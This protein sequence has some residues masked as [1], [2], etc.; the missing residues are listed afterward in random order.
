[1]RRIRVARW[2]SSKS[3]ASRFGSSSPRSIWSSS[4]IIRSTRR[5]TA[6]GQVEEHRRDA[7]P[8]GGLL[9]R[10]PDRLAVDHVE[11]LGHLADLV[12]V[13]EL[14]RV[15]DLADDVVGAAVAEVAHVAQPGDRLGQVAVGHRERAL[16]QPAQREVERAGQHDGE[17]DGD[18]QDQQHQDRPRW[19]PAGSPTEL[20][21]AAWSHDLRLEPLL[22]PAHQVDDRAEGLGDAPSGCT[23]V[24]ERLSRVETWSARLTASP[25]TVLSTSARCAGVA[26]RAKASERLLLAGLVAMKRGELLGAEVAGGPGGVR[27]RLLLGGAGLGPGERGDRAQAVGDRAVT[28]ELAEHLA[29]ADQ[30][31]DA[32]RR[33]AAPPRRP[34]SRPRSVT[35]LRVA[36]IV[37]QVVV[38]PVQ[39]VLHRGRRVVELAA[40]RGVRLDPR[41]GLRDRRVV[42]RPVVGLAGV[43]AGTAPPPSAP[44]AGT[45]SGRRRRW[46]ARSGPRP[47]AA[48]SARLPTSIEPDGGQRQHGHQRHE[49]DQG[50]LGPDPRASRRRG[51]PA[52]LH[53]AGVRGRS[54]AGSKI[55]CSRHLLRGH[56]RISSPARCLRPG[57]FRSR[58]KARPHAARP[59]FHQNRRRFGKSEYRPKRVP[60]RLTIARS[61]RQSTLPWALTC[62]NMTMATVRVGAVTVIHQDSNHYVG[63]PSRVHRSGAA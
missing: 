63:K 39:P 37:L 1:M 34:R 47:G 21:S 30:V 49:Q 42:R 35:L 53:A 50:Q 41:V 44:C 33:S 25:V 8:Q 48:S 23:G 27:D 56:P 28:G 18:D 5:L 2:S 54:Q 12:A 59:R 38:D 52:P 22:G 19:R 61:V 7:G 11:R 58:G 4:P 31:G 9:G 57:P 45:G 15:A 55:R 16:A 36:S 14:D 17:R 3:W 40:V 26:T 60:S 43:G 24:A 20:S 46:R 51:K 13:V 6:A 32:R 10:D 29:V 62:T